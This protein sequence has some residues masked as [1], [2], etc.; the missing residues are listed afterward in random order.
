ML[1]LESLVDNILASEGQILLGLDY[2]TDALGLT[3]KKMEGIFTTTIRQYARRRPL[4][5]TKDF[6]TGAP[7]YMPSNTLGIKSIRWGIL[8]DYPRFFQDK[9]DE[10]TY[11]YDMGNK[12]L[13]V[14]PPNTAVKVTYLSV[15]TITKSDEVRESF[16]P[17]NNETVYEDIMQSSFR[18]GTLK[19][20]KG[21]FSMSEIA[22]NSNS[23]PGKIVLSG[24][25]GTGEIDIAT[26][27]F[28]VNLNDTT[29]GELNFT[30]YPKYYCCKELDIGDYIFYKFFALNILRSIA[31]LKAQNT[32]P[33]LHNID[34]TSEDLMDR[35]RFLEKEVNILLKS[36]ISFGG[37]A[38]I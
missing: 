1:Y 34:L 6:L 13:K 36:T 18:Q 7:I 11:E 35:V 37:L 21:T 15:P 17:V 4:E 19:I 24:T 14:F 30:Y 38:Q 2:I 5:V 32:Q 25:L 12:I 23:N 28:F 29:G 9:W 20:T 10:I 33:E 27:E 22:R 8:P 16:Y 3:M 26:R 31:S